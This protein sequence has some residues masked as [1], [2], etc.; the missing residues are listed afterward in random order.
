MSKFILKV[1]WLD[2]N[3]ALAV[4]Q[5]V[6]NGTSP[7]T[8]YFFWPRNDAWE[9]LKTELEG[10][11]TLHKKASFLELHFDVRG[12]VLLSCDVSTE[13]FNHTVETNFDLIV[14]FGTSNDTDPDEILM[15]PEG[16]YQINVAQHFYEMIVLSLPLKRIHPGIRNGTLKNDILSKLEQLDPQN[17]KSAPHK[18]P[19]WEKLKSLL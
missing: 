3:V 6:G 10:K 19:R 4:D 5:V 18:D 9:Q 7:L 17:R 13:L 12:K 8:C 16:S 11:L 15:I 2:D 1:V 14:K